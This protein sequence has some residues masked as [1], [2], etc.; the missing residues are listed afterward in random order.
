[1]TITAITGVDGVTNQFKDPTMDP[2]KWA[3]LAVITEVTSSSTCVSTNLKGCGGCRAYAKKAN[4]MFNKDL[5]WYMDNSFCN[6][7]MSLIEDPTT[8]LVVRLLI[9]MLWFISFFLLCVMAPG[10]VSLPPCLC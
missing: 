2:M 10:K 4:I 1:V 9:F 6:N 3:A 5:C 8:N 7:F